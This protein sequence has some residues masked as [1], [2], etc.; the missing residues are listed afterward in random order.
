MAGILILPGDG[1]G[2]EI[3]DASL[4]VLAAAQERFGFD[5]E[6]TEVLAGGIG[7]DTYGEAVRDEDLEVML[8]SDAVFLGDVGGAKWDDPESAAVAGAWDRN[9]LV[10]IFEQV[11]G[12]DLLDELRHA[13]EAATGATEVELA[14]LR[15]GVQRQLGD[16]GASQVQVGQPGGV[17]QRQ[18][19][20][21]LH[22]RRVDRGHPRGGESIR[23]R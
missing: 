1:I 15:P 4:T 21:D 7:I 18:P 19:A 2:P 11:T 22:P 10:T 6:W 16:G 5:I 12:T 14:Q 23:H 3:V 13:L 17:A 8:E 20:L 9:A